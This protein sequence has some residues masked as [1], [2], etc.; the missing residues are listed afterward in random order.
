MTD[1]IS[2]LIGKD[3]EGSGCKLILGTNPAFAWRDCGKP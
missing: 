2:D 3:L 1:V